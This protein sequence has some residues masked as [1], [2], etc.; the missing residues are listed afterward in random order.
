M[1][2]AL[3]LKYCLPIFRVMFTTS[4]ALVSEPFKNPST[5]NC[6][7]VMGFSPRSLAKD[8]NM[9]VRCE[10]VSSSALCDVVD[11]LRT[12]PMFAMGKAVVS[13]LLTA[14]AT[15]DL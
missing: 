1:T 4:K 2:R 15:V 7:C 10:P 3:T 5:F 8:A 6:T 13:F 9:K 12:K 14:D 11:L